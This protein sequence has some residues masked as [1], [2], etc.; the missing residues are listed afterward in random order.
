[1]GKSR[2]GGRSQE[3]WSEE[4]EEQ[5]WVGL[6]IPWFSRQHPRYPTESFSPPHPNPALNLE[7]LSGSNVPPIPT[8]LSPTSPPRLPR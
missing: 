2:V 6:G 8:A 7:H 4:G 1:M 5:V 3:V